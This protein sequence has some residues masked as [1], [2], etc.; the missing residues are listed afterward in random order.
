M[1]DVVWRR[2]VTLD[3]QHYDKPKVR[4]PP[5]GPERRK[6]EAHLERWLAE[7]PQV[8]EQPLASP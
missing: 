4:Q 3:G 2:L 8:I 6:V 1:P 5:S 7:N